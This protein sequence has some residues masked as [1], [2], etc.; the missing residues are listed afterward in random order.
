MARLKNKVVLI[1]GAAGGI[2]SATAELFLKEGASVLL[3]D[4]DE[5]KINDLSD[6]VDQPDK[7]ASIKCDVSSLEDN[8]TAVKKAVDHFGG[9]DIV[10][11]NAG[12]EGEVKP[13]VDYPVDTFNKVLDIN[14]KGVFYAIKAAF[15][16][17][18]KRGG[19]SFI[20]TSSVAGLM[21]TGNMSAYTT[22]KHAVIGLMREAAKEGALHNIR[23]N[24]VN[25]APVNNRMMR[26][27][28]SGFSP[29]NSEDAKEQFE[30]MIPLQRYAENGD[31]AKLMLFLASDESSYITGTVNPVDGGMTA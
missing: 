11:A 19:G 10:V 20:I 25:P 28:E 21:G 6:K 18:K 2:G 1:T 12:I 31:V 17:L 26:S 9:L 13:I 5:D 24:T 22:S 23:A 3:A 27:L 16:E 15:P 7:I 14:V 8:I 29:D 30:A 4:I